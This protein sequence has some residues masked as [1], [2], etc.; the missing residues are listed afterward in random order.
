MG[1]LWSPTFFNF[2]E[3]IEEIIS[4]EKGIS[5]LTYEKGPD[6]IKGLTKPTLFRINDFTFAF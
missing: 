5:G 6:Y 4:S 3:K 1:L 2:G